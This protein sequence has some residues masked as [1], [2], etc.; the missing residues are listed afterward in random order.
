MDLKLEQ[1]QN[2]IRFFST[3][4]P[5]EWVKKQSASI[6]GVNLD[7]APE[8]LQRREAVFSI[9]P[10]EEPPKPVY[11]ERGEL[12]TAYHDEDESANEGHKKS[13]LPEHDA[14]EKEDMNPNTSPDAPLQLHVFLETVKE[15]LRTQSTI[16]RNS[17]LKLILSVN[18]PVLKLNPGVEKQAKIHIPS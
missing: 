9:E 15:T 6:A 12:L 7:A 13:L 18:L 17:V 10:L 4:R 8:E 5:Q 2:G 14:N 16:E 1:L 3:S 11:N